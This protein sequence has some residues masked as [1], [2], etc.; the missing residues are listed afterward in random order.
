LTQVTEALRV[1]NIDGREFIRTAPLQ[2]WTQ[3]FAPLPE[4]PALKRKKD[5]EARKAR[6]AAA[7]AK[8]T[9]DDAA[10]DPPT[11]AL[12]QVSIAR[13]P[14]SEPIKLQPQM[15]DHFVMNLPASALEFLDAYNGCCKPLLGQPDFPGVKEAKMPLI[16]T[17]CFTREVE[18]SAAAEAD[19]CKRASGYLGYPVEPTM[20]GYHLHLVRSVAP[21]KDMYCLTFRLPREVAFN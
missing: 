15:I 13:S 4:P 8:N 17:H 14:S 9:K 11:A 1:S 3:P 2:A 12:K 18:E 16:H 20:D 21:N 6:E 5:K 7:A 19:I 10:D